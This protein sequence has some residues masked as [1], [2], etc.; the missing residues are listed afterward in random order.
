MESVRIVFTHSSS[1]VRWSVSTV[2]WLLCVD[3]L[4][5]NYRSPGSEPTSPVKVEACRLHSG[6]QT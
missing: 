4:A 5:G 2:I 3:C 1:S 6:M